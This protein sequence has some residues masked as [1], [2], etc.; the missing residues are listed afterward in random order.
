M[1][2]IRLPQHLIE[3]L[4]RR[5]ANRLQR[6]VKDWRSNA[7]P[8]RFQHTLDSSPKKAKPDLPYRRLPRS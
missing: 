8:H 3:R 6:D 1:E 2:D 5:W 7:V 4:E